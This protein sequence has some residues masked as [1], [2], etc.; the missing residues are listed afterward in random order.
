MEEQMVSKTRFGIIYEK[1]AI[2]RFF[3]K[4]EIGED[5]IGWF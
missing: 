5:G 4:R 2:E 1:I 3:G